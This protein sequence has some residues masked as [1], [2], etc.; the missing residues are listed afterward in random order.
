[1]FCEAGSGGVA[2]FE[3]PLRFA[4]DAWHCFNCSEQVGFCRWIL[5]VRVDEEQVGFAV[6]IFDSN[7]EAI[8]TSGFRQ[9]DLCGKVATEVF[10]DNAV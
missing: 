1:M 9:C 2:P 3:G 7:L 4:L 10:V 8:K 6:D 5:G